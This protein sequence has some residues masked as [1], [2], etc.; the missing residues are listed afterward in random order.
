MITQAKGDSRNA[1]QEILIQQSGYQKMN[2]EKLNDKQ[3]T[4]L[5][6]YINTRT[7]EINEYAKNY[8]E[9]A[10]AELKEAQ[11]QQQEYEHTNLLVSLVL[12]I[13][14]ILAGV[15]AA[16]FSAGVA[17]PLVIS[18]FATV[19][20][21]VQT[22]RKTDKDIELKE[23]EEKLTEQLTLLRTAEKRMEND[24]LRDKKTELE[25][26]RDQ[27]LA[28][29]NKDYAKMLEMEIQQIDAALNS[30]TLD[31]QDGFLKFDN[32]R[33][34]EDSLRVNMLT[35][36]LRLLASV[37]KAQHEG[38]NIVASELSLPAATVSNYGSEI[39][40]KDV[41]VLL[42]TVSKKGSLEL[43]TAQAYNKGAQLRQ[44]IKEAKTGLAE[45]VIGRV[46]FMLVDVA[47]F[48]AGGGVVQNV[49]R[50][51]GESVYNF[52]GK[53][54]KAARAKY[55]PNRAAIFADNPQ[56]APADFEEIYAEVLSGS[57]Q[58]MRDLTENKKALD[59]ER[60]LQVLDD[61]QRLQRLENIEIALN[62]AVKNS[63][64]I[65]HQE[66]TDKKTRTQDTF[67]KIAVQQVFS[68]LQDVVQK[69]KQL[70]EIQIQSINQKVDQRTEL[71]NAGF[72][73]LVSVFAG[74]LGGQSSIAS[75]DNNLDD[76]F[77][78]GLAKSILDQNKN[79]IFDL[80]IG[81]SDLKLRAENQGASYG[82]AQS[83]LSDFD[84]DD[85]WQ[86]DARGNVTVDQT[87]L[88]RKYAKLQRALMLDQ[89][90]AA[91]QSAR[92]K[93]R[94]VVHMELA[95]KS[96][97]GV[98]L[99]QTLTGLNR[100]SLLAKWTILV[101]KA[102]ARAEQLSRKNIR[103]T[104]LQRDFLTSLVSASVSSLGYAGGMQSEQALALG[105]LT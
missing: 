46:F 33:Y 91:L 14:T 62:A 65:I 93:S 76:A 79:N 32:E 44:E 18:A 83:G 72:N 92:Q 75:R 25:K 1:I 30:S 37:Q 50:G 99:T 54:K 67:A 36:L 53:A 71:L 26:L 90:L 16:I 19:V 86:E 66:L 45:Y 73:I 70:T 55:D 27:A 103:T 17:A 87:V 98:G 35:M 94:E 23:K 42:E 88:L 105:S 40:N 7:K 31:Y 101:D 80:A 12:G 84:S 49:L 47:T 64:N 6:N 61:L 100:E 24:F 68:L 81:D 95:E 11:R 3:T 56:T 52:T 58:L 77:A 96:A 38:R 10:E 41:M 104:D 51:L 69:Q 34:V 22:I 13:V 4:Y 48:G 59:Y 20:D 57:S 97:A 28:S 60:Y 89:A 8:N 102:Y 82:G 15:I 39:V 2:I 78:Y 29:G 21:V 74:W 63:R 5:T 43:Q 85:L 9:K